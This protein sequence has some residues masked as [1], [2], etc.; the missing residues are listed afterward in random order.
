MTATEGKLNPE[1]YILTIAVTLHRGETAG[2]GDLINGVMLKAKE[3]VS[4]VKSEEERGGSLAGAIEA[5]VRAR[6]MQNF[7]E[8]GTLLTMSQVEFAN[9]QEYL[10]GI[11]G[12]CGELQRCQHLHPPPSTLHHLPSGVLIASF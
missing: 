1:P 5:C 6:A 12:F 10:A 7:F 9:R 11:M 4:H 2:P 3:G 8:T